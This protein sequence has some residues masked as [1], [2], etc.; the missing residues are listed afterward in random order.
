MKTLADTEFRKRCEELIKSWRGPVKGRSGASRQC[1]H[2]L[3]S[4]LAAPASQPSAQM[5]PMEVLREHLYG[6]ASFA[7]SGLCLCSCGWVGTSFIDHLATFAVSVP[8]ASETH[9][10]ETGQGS[11]IPCD[12]C[13]GS[14]SLGR[15][16]DGRLISCEWCGGH[17]DSLGTGRYEINRPT[18]D[19]TDRIRALAPHSDGRRDLEARLDEA[20]QWHRSC[21][22]NGRYCRGQNRINELTRQL[23]ALKGEAD[24]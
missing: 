24:V 2:E 9:A 7:K 17:E 1:A 18:A 3:A 6:G 22:C 11:C 14:G 15:A 4:A 13:G 16:G 23:A 21:E 12:H 19:E 5:V 20:E 10:F 8:A